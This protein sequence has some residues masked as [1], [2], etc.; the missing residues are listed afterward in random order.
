MVWPRRLTRTK[1]KDIGTDKSPEMVTGKKLKGNENKV[2]ALLMLL[3]RLRLRRHTK[4]IES[5]QER[6]FYC[7]FYLF[8]PLTVIDSYDGGGRDMKQQYD[9][10]II[11]ANFSFSCML[12]TSSRTTSVNNGWNQVGCLVKN[13]SISYVTS[14]ALDKHRC[15]VHSSFGKIT[16]HKLPITMVKTKTR[17]AC[18]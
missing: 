8:F 4:D 1:Q 14:D 16:C 18:R 15:E 6:S 13:R 2:E 7:H 12:C 9:S 3:R 10:P 5:H 11:I 17:G